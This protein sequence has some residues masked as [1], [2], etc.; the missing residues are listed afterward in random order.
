MPKKG[1]AGFTS[2]VKPF[3]DLGNREFLFVRDMPSTI[4]RSLRSE[5]GAADRRKAARHSKKKFAR[6]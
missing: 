3:Y 2:A 6:R 5:I 1:K 4:E